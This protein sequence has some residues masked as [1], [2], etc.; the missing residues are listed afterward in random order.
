MKR[1]AACARRLAVVLLASATGLTPAAL[2]AMGQGVNILST[3]TDQEVKLGLDKSIVVDLPADATDILVANPEVADAVTRT[4]RRIYFFGK[5]VGRTNVFVFGAGGNQLASFDLVIERDVAGLVQYL[6]RFLPTANIDAEI[7]NDNVVL[8]GTVRS[9]LDASKA[10]Q[11]ATIYVTGGE[12]TGGEVIATDINGL[13]SEKT[14]SIVNLLQLVG[15]DQVMLRVTVAEVTRRALKDLGVN[16]SLNSATGSSAFNLTGT[17]EAGQL[18]LGGSGTIGGYEL[19]ATLNALEQ[20]GVMRTVAEPT[21][22]AVS[23]REATF[24]V[25]AEGTVTVVGDDNSSTESVEYGVTLNFTP[26]VLAEGR[27]ALQIETELNEPTNELTIEAGSN[28]TVQQRKTRRASTE[29]EMSSGGTMMMAGLIRDQFSIDQNRTPGLGRIPIFGTLF[30]ERS[31]ERT[32]TELVVIVRPFLVRQTSP[33]Q[34]Q[35]PDYGFEPAADGPQNFLGRV[36]RLYGV[37]RK[38]STLPAWRGNVGYIYK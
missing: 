17:S 1:I 2:P 4:S 38:K 20:N 33:D 21:L 6:R 32:E 24:Q 14:S 35:R 29:V 10:E 31:Y 19:D 30:R 25:G 3:S 23:G 12:A 37:A 34:I 18:T 27:I 36:N 13:T 7:V 8:T 28:A 26:T 15:Q 22:V 9:P 5:K 11:L 16:L